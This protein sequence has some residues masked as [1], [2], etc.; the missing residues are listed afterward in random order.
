M[1]AREIPFCFWRLWNFVHGLRL[2][3]RFEESCA[4]IRSFVNNMDETSSERLEEA[5]GD[6]PWFYETCRVNGVQV[7]KKAWYDALSE[8]TACI[9]IHLW[10]VFRNQ[11]VQVFEYKT[12]MVWGPAWAGPFNMALISGWFRDLFLLR[13]FEEDSNNQNLQKIGTVRIR[14]RQ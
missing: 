4:L 13:S 9:E 3:M 7:E 2:L 14:P 5:A 12:L 11:S 1:I 6:F 8:S 10:P